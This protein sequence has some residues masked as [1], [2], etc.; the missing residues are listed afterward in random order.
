LRL[1]FVHARLRQVGFSNIARVKPVLLG[2]NKLLK[3]I[4]GIALLFERSLRGQSGNE[5]L[6]G[7][8]FLVAQK[9]LN[10]GRCGTVGMV[11][12]ANSPLPFAKKLNWLIDAYARGFRQCLRAV[13]TQVT[14]ITE[15]KIWIGEFLG[16]GDG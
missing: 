11:R 10:R 8:E 16:D 3:I 14:T 13:K 4:R 7:I 2:G 5:S 6:R 15:I 1:E 9:I 12:C